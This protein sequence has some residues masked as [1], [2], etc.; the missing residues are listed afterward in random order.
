MADN[1][2]NPFLEIPVARPEEY[3]VRV[4][5]GWT[6]GDGTFDRVQDHMKTKS[7]VPRPPHFELA[8]RSMAALTSLQISRD[9]PITMTAMD[10]TTSQLWNY[11]PPEVKDIAFVAPPCGPELWGSDDRQNAEMY[12]RMKNEPKALDERGEYRFYAELKEKPWVIWPI[13]V[14][15]EWGKDFLVVAWHAHATPKSPRT[16]DRI[17]S[18]ILYDSRRNPQPDGDGKHSQIQPRLD[19]IN[20]RLATFLQRGGLSIAGTTA[21]YGHCS[22]M[23]LK[24]NSSGERCFAAVKDLLNYLTLNVLEHN[25]L[26]EKHEWPNLSKWVFPYVCRIEMTG[27]AAWTLMASHGFEARIALECLEPHL[28]FEVVVDGTKR[29]L[30]PNGLSGPLRGSPITDRDYRLDPAAVARPLQE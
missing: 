10:V 6:L 2:V 12:E 19:R 28:G 14:E 15:D 23:G 21:W 20:G 9:A 24:E 17:G 5:D 22:P 3:V 16:Y 26:Q 4:G 30:K 25:T 7:D 11:L 8:F 29:M 27:I 1:T 18:Y 13:W